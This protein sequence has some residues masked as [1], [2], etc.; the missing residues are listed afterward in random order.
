MLM[1]SAVMDTP[2]DSNDSF[3]LLLTAVTFTSC[4][5]FTARVTIAP[6][7]STESSLAFNDF[8]WACKAA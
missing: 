3:K 8:K 7:K 6:R 4:K 2:N 1:P 5:Y